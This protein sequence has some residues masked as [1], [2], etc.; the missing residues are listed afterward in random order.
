MGVWGIE[1]TKIIGISFPDSLDLSLP[2]SSA[3]KVHFHGITINGNWHLRWQ[4]ERV[5]LWGVEEVGRGQGGGVITPPQSIKSTRNHH[6]QPSFVLLPYISVYAYSDH[7]SESQNARSLI[8]GRAS[9]G[10]REGG[11]WKDRNVRTRETRNRT[12]QRI[13]KKT[14]RYRRRK[15]GKRENTMSLRDAVPRRSSTL[16]LSSSWRLLRTLWRFLTFAT[17]T[18]RRFRATT[19]IVN[20]ARSRPSTAH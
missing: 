1:H 19:A 16:I 6:W 5:R 15:I 10:R 7:I 13:E 20:K 11:L 17:E 2:A 8:K 9:G 12:R 3:N 18:K 4:G 14:F